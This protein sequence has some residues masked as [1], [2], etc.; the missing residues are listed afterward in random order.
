MTTEAP[1]KETIDVSGGEEC[2]V[3]GGF[4]ISQ[5]KC[6]RCLDCGWTY[7]DEEEI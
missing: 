6:K 1:E 2:P 7:C 3:C 5:D 4:V